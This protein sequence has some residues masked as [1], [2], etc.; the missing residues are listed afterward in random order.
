V[1]SM[2]LTLTTTMMTITHCHQV[3][4][5][6][7]RH[8]HP[9]ER[10]PHLCSTLQLLVRIVLKLLSPVAMLVPQQPPIYSTASQG[11]LILQCR[12]SGMKN[13]PIVTL[14]TL[15]CLPKH[16]SFV[17]YRLPLRTY[18]INCSTCG[19]ASMKPSVLVTVQSYA[20]R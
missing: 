13:V 11:H 6:F 4:M 10:H 8:P 7:D 17:T 16:S 2:T 12:E 9:F 18:G 19:A 15:N 3:R 1:I 5:M 14:R 20:S